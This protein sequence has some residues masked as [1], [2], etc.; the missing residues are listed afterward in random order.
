MEAV[1]PESPLGQELMAFE[2]ARQD[3]L[4]AADAQALD[5]LMAPDLTHVHSSGQV[6]GKA[7]FLAHVAKMGGFVSIE[8]GEITLRSDGRTALISGPT[9]NTVRRLDSGAIA[10]L[11]GFGTVVARRGSADWQVV[12]SQITR[13]S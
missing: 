6:H 2:I 5:R 1:T 10:V 9:R 8:R 12:L 13:K 4:V 7:E 3:A 11:D